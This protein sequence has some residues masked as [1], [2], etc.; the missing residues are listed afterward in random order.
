MHALPS[1]EISVSRFYGV[2]PHRRAYS[3]FAWCETVTCLFATRWSEDG[4]GA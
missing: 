3:V 4:T 1:M 2:S